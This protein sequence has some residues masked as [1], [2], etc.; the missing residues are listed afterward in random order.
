MIYPAIDIYF[1]TD[2]LP[3]LEFLQRTQWYTS[4]QI[5][6]LQNDRL[7]KLIVHAYNNVPYYNKLFKELKLT[8]YDIETTDDLMKLPILTKS[9]IKNN[10]ESLIAQ[11]I[12]KSKLLIKTT[13]GSTGNPLKFVRDKESMGHIRA[14]QY[15][16]F[17]WAGLD[18]FGDKW[19]SLTSSLY[20]D[21]LYK[22]IKVKLYLKLLR[23]KRLATFG[24]TDQDLCEYT[25]VI[26]KFNPKT[27]YGYASSLF[28]MANFLYKN[29][30]HDIK[31]KSII[32]DSETLYPHYRQRIEKQFN[33]KVFDHYGSKEA[34][35]AQ[36]CEE[37]NGYHIAAENLYLEIIKDG[38]RVLEGELGKIVVTDFTNYGMPLIRYENG[39]LGIPSSKNCRCGRGLPLIESIVGRMNDILISSNGKIIPSTYIPDVFQK[40]GDDVKQYQVIQSQAGELLIKIVKEK[41]YQDITSEH[42]IKSLENHFVKDSIKF[43]FVDTISLPES[44]KHR[45]VISEVSSKIL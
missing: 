26:Q 34:D 37:H 43:E 25:K 12:P 32:S 2:T 44:G 40:F 15:R 45:F 13:G 23:Q 8:P 20:D 21:E 16:F 41:S 11:N 19:V 14:A 31:V 1:K 30:I 18:F 4:E 3:N 10:F 29:D 7:K 9:D 35:Y 38:M 22:K 27:L 5:K 33:C 24:V 39:D 42:I 17:E 36:E 6:Q 28:A